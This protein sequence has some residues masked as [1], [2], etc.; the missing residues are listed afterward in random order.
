MTA[1]RS[2]PGQ[3]LC[4]QCM[5]RGER[6]E[7]AGASEAVAG[8]RR[9]LGA[10]QALSVCGITIGLRQSWLWSPK[11]ASVRAAASSAGSIKGRGW[12]TLWCAM[13]RPAAGGRGIRTLDPPAWCGPESES[14]PDALD[15]AARIERARFAADS[16]LEGT[17]FEPSVPRHGE[18]SWRPV[19]LAI[20][21]DM[22][23][24]VRRRG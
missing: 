24:G 10:V 3:R 8:N 16:P 21:R 9:Y 2:P 6:D 4:K 15:C 17:G 13:R 7:R 11:R 14:F 22:R 20:W 19:S 5:L 18:L 12:L 1:I 23:H